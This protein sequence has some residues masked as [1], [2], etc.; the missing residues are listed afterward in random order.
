MSFINKRITKRIEEIAMELTRIFS[1]VDTNGEIEISN[2]VYEI[3]GNIPY[4]KENPNDLFFVHTNDKL[5][6][7]SVVA[8]LRGKK[9]SK[10]TVVLIGHTDTVGISDYGELAEYANN[11]YELAERFKNIRLDEATR[12]D[13]ESGE[14]LF[15]RGIFDMKSG[16][17]VIITL[18]EEIA[19][20]LDNF[21][22]NL[23][24]AA[25]CDEEANSSGMLSVVPKLVELQEKEGFEYLALLDTD[26]ITA[27]FIGDENKNIYIGTVGKLMPSFLVVGKETHVGESFNGIDPNEIS[28]AIMSRINMNTEFCDIVDG[29]VSL[30]PIS[31]Y[32]RDQKPEY[33]VQVG[34][35]AILYFNYATH[36]STPD[37]VLEKMKNAAYEA[38]ESVVLKLNK[39][40][41]KFCSMSSNRIYKK[42]PWEARVLSYTELLEKVREE[43][44]EIDN[45]LTNYS[46]ELLKDD[47]ID[48]RVFAQRIVEKLQASWKDQN[49]VVVVYFSPPYYPHIYIDG[50]NP[51]DKA[52]IDAVDNAVK[53][54]VTDYKLAYKKFFPYISDL[55]YGAAPKDSAII[56]ALKD[57]MPGFGIKYSLPLEAMQKL[58]LPV[59]DIG[60][61]GYDAHKFTER[62]EKRYSYTVTPEL[63][64][65][66]VMKL[67]NNKLL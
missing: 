57:N 11:P 42:L 27:E 35:T 29:E 4:F 23:I 63:V 60:C 12:K 50:T 59:L 8:I 58:S 30:P 61:F 31:L 15:G 21:E 9:V 28:S 45:I 54:T 56:A 66:T 36:I 6:R 65:K 14:Y 64:Y 24:F 53:S 40:Y 16:D 41:E 44:P 34:K 26:Y 19:K 52:L 13:L 39:Q 25:V 18:M 37:M 55:S 33:S 67:L 51:K 48:I 38:F 2:K 49:P 22:G 47:S 5:G 1:V 43:N 10:K 46:K 17:A 7:K 3:M 20:D 32:Q 62:V